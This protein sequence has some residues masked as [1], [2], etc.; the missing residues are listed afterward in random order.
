MSLKAVP[1][2]RDAY[3]CNNDVSNAALKPIAS[4]RLGEGARLQARSWK[5]EDLSILQ[6]TV[7]VIEGTLRWT[8]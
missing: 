1:F 8:K 4:Q 5:A 6:F 7:T 3:L 2:I